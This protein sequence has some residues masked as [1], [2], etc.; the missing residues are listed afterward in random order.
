MAKIG[1]DDLSHHI[2]DHLGQKSQNIK[3]TF[4]GGRPSAHGRAIMENIVTLEF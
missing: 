1:V 3:F 2:F 4:Q